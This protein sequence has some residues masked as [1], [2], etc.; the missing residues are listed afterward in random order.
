MVIV[1]VMINNVNKYIYDLKNFL[2]LVIKD[3]WMMCF[4]GENVFVFNY[5]CKLIIFV[6]NCWIDWW[7]GV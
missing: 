6:M 1:N 3:R 7:R 2:L 4:G 5:R